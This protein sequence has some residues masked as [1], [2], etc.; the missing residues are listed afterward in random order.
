MLII[1]FLVTCI[2]CTSL[3]HRTY[4]DEEGALRG[5]DPVAYFNE[6]KPV[7]GASDIRYEYNDATWFF[8]NEENRDLF[9]QNP[10]S[11]G[12]QY[13]GYCAYAMSKGFIVSSDPLAWHVKNDK[14]Y[15]NYS[16]GVRET[17]LKNTAVYIEKADEHWMK[18]LKHDIDQ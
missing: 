5:Y 14:L 9:K 7:K 18:K 1:A 8:A 11:F 2:G 4:S 15:L 13:G 16:L 6:A 17:W 3:K 12:P 10:E